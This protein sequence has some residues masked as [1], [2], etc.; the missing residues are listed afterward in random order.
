MIL[1]RCSKEADTEEDSGVD[2]GRVG[3]VASEVRVTLR[4]ETGGTEEYPSLVTEDQEQRSHSSSASQHNSVSCL[5][6][7]LLSLIIIK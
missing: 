7:S 5:I 4:E 2:S 6:S 3:E 1:T